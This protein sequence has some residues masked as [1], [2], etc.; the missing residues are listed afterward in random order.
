MTTQ[1]LPEVPQGQDPY[2]TISLRDGVI[3]SDATATSGTSQQYETVS[4]LV[5][6]ANGYKISNVTIQAGALIRPYSIIGDSAVI[7]HGAE[8]K[9]CI[10]QNKA[11]VQ[12]YEKNNSKAQQFEIANVENEY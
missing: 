10:I 2:G 3:V 5:N 7:G 4:F 9:H 8:I 6:P 1:V 12:I 11:K